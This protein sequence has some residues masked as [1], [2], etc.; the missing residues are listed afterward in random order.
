ML[1]KCLLTV[2]NPGRLGG[3]RPPSTERA[4]LAAVLLYGL[5]GLIHTETQRAL[6]INYWNMLSS[7]NALWK[8]DPLSY[9]LCVLLWAQQQ[10]PSLLLSSPKFYFQPVINTGHLATEITENVLTSANGRLLKVSKASLNND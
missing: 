9:S 2:S 10:R 6:E 8:R 7:F 3:P 1:R 5:V 4:N